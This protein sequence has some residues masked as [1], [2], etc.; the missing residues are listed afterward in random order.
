MFKILYRTLIILFAAALIAFGLSWFSG[1]SAGQSLFA[2]GGGHERAFTQNAQA[3]I[4]TGQPAALTPRGNFG[5]GGHEGGVNITR[6]L[7]D[8]PGKIGVIAAITLAVVVVRK[9]LSILT[10]RLHKRGPGTAIPA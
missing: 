10:L 6:A 4:T 2:S 9:F 7:A 3:T 1:T 8:L 5:G